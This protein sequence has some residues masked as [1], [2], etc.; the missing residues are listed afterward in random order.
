MNFPTR[1]HTWLLHAGSSAQRRAARP[2]FRCG[3]WLPLALA[4]ALAAC[5]VQIPEAA[6]FT[7]EDADV[8]ALADAGDVGTD[9]GGGIDTLAGD[10]AQTDA[11]GD[12]TAGPCAGG[13]DD[14]NPCTEDKCGTAG[15]C[16]HVS[17]DG[18][19]CSD[20][21]A[22]I[23]GATCAGGKC[24]G[25][26]PKVC[27][28]N[29]PCTADA[30]LPA[31]GCTYTDDD[32][33]GCSDSDS[34]TVDD[35]CLGGKCKGAPM[36][37]GAD[38]CNN[39][40]CI[41]GEC[42]AAPKLSGL[43][44][45]D[46]DACT[47]ATTCN[48]K[49]LCSGGEITN[50]DD[51][52]ACTTDSC[53]SKQ[54]CLHDL[55]T[56][57]CSDNDACT[58]GDA[59]VGGT[60]NPGTGKVCD[61]GNGCTADLCNP[62]DGACAAT[63]TADPCSDGNACTV[64]DA[65]A[66]GKCVPGASLGCDDQNPCTIDSCDAE[67]GACSYAFN[68]ATCE[69]GDGCTVG[70]V[71]VE[72]Q[73]TGGA[74]KQCVDSD[75]CTSDSCDAATGDCAHA[76]IA[77]CG[78]VCTTTADCKAGD[79]CNTA[80]CLSSKCVF[81]PTAAACDDGDACTLAD[82]CQA[83]ACK[84]LSQKNCDDGNPCTDDACA[85]GT[86]AS[87]AN[88]APCSD[89]DA[90]TLG[91]VCAASA[92]VAGTAKVC[93]DGNPCTADACDKQS[94][95]CGSTPNTAA[96][97]DK[98]PCT[99]GDVC[100]DG[101]CLAGGPVNC[102]D[103]N[104][105][106]N[107]SCDPKTGKCLY[108]NSSAPCSDG[109]ACTQGDACAG[110]TCA[111]GTAKSCDDSNPC[112]NDS[113]DPATAACKNVANAADC[114]DGDACTIGDICAAS[115]CKA[116]AA[117]VCADSDTCTNDAC[118]PASGNCVYK[119]ISGCGG[120]CAAAGDCTDGNVCTTDSCVGGKCAFPP[121]TANC[122]DANGCTVGD[123][124]SS[125]S[126]KAGSAKVCDDGNPCTTDACDSKTG[127]CTNAAN[128]ANCDDGNA[129]TAGDQCGS[130]KC[131]AG[132]PIACNDGNPCTDD[133]CDPTSGQCKAAANAAACDDG[134]ACTQGDLCSQA[135]CQAGAAKNCD[136]TNPC[137]TDSCDAATGTCKN[138]ANTL[139]CNDNNACTQGDVCS[140][141]KCQPGA[142]KNCDDGKVCTDD[143]C[144]KTTGACVAAANTATCDDGNKCTLQDVCS[145]GACKA[146]TAVV[147][148]DKDACTNDSCN[149]GDGKCLYAPKIGCGG[150]C[151]T[152]ADCNDGNLCTT[153]QCTSGK[154]TAPSNTAFCDDGNACT[155]NDVCSGG[156]CKSG[157]AKVCD[158]TNPCT[159]DSCNPA[160]G[161]CTY[162]NNTSPCNDNNAC[163]VGDVC[164]AAV[165]KP[166]AAKNCD[167]GKV[168]TDDSCSTSTGNC[169]NTNNTAVCTD[170]NACTSGDVCSGGACVGPTAVNC[171]DGKV[172]S[173]D[174]C[175]TS[176]GCKH[177][178]NT[179]PCSDGSA[180][181]TSDTCSN[182][183]CVG[184]VA[185]NCDDSILCTTD[186]CDPAAGCKHAN[187]TVAC[188]DG[189]VCTQNDA[190]SGGS[191][192]PGA[193]FACNDNDG[194]TTD[195]CNPSDGACVFKPIIGCGGNCASASDCNDANPC[196]NDTC[197]NGKCAHSNNTVSCNDNNACTTSDTCG[198]GACIG[199]AA[200]N[201]D[202]NNPCTTDS[203]D[204]STGCKKVNNTAAC[205]DNNAC[206]TGD[207][208]NG[209]TCV[210]GAAPNCDDNNPCTTDSC[211]TATGCKKVNNT[212]TC[213][214]GSACTTSDT[215]N[216]GACVGTAVNCDDKN[217]CT[218]DSCDKTA[219]CQYQTVA[220]NTPCDDGNACTAGEACSSGTCKGGNQVWV[221]TLAGEVPSP[222]NGFGSGSY[223]DGVGGKARFNSPAGIVYSPKGATLFVADS[224]NHLIRYISSN[225]TVGTVA[226]KQGTAGASD[227][228]GTS[229]TFNL[230][231][232][233]AIGAGDVLLVA[234]TNNS[235]IREIA[236][237]TTVST[238]TGMAGV[239]N[240]N[241][242]L[243]KAKFKAPKGIAVSATGL[244]AVADTGNHAIRLINGNSVTTLAGGLG[245]GYVDGSPTQAKF[246]GPTGIGFDAKG[247]VW[248]ADM[249]N[250]R[251]RVV[252]PNGTVSTA[253]GDGTAGFLDSITPLYARFYYP[254]GLAVLPVPNGVAVLISDSY[255]GRIRRGGGN[256]VTTFAG[257]GLGATDGPGSSAAF[258]LPGGIAV[259]G[260]GTV[261]VADQYNHTIRR[262]R[263]LTSPCTIGNAC[264]AAGQWNPVNSC[265]WCDP[266]SNPS[267][268]S[269]K[270]GCDDGSPCTT[271]DTCGG[272]GCGG[273]GT[274]CNDGNSCTDDVCD[275]V[276]G[277]CS[278]TNN[279]AS[280]NDNNPCTVGD[281][282]GQGSC[283]A[284][285]GNKCDDNNLCTTDNCNS[286]TGG[287]T[288]SN[289][290]NGTACAGSAAQAYPFCSAG[291]CTGLE[292]SALNLVWSPANVGA[293][294]LT[295][296]TRGADNN[297]LVSGFGVAA[298]GGSP[299]S[300]I[301]QV[302]VAAS[303]P[304]MTQVFGTSPREIW[305]LAKRL[306]VGGSQST[307]TA[308][309]YVSQTGLYSA[310]NG[311]QISGGPTLTD[312]L[313]ILR[314][315]M[316][317]PD[318]TT[319]D[320]TYF[321]GG[322]ADNPT[323]TTSKSTL[324]RMKWQSANNSWASTGAGTLRGE[325]GVY[326]SFVS[327]ASAC[328]SAFVPAHVAGIYAVTADE[329]FFAVNTTSPSAAIVNVWT[330][331]NSMN[332]TCASY[333]PGGAFQA[334]TSTGSWAYKFP[335]GAT[336]TGVHGSAN[337]HVL[338]VGYTSSNTAHIARF[339]GAG[340]WAAESPN[341]TMP[342]GWPAFGSATIKP[343][344]VLVRSADAWV[345]GVASQ[346]ICNYMFVLHGTAVG[347][348]WVWDKMVISN[349][350]AV[351][352]DSGNPGHLSVTRIWGDPVDGFVYI[353]GSVAKDSNGGSLV[354]VNAASLGQ[355]A[356]LW[357]VK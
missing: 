97:D 37:C 100:A 55:A 155:L 300:A 93:D 10:D 51:A 158:D 110:G 157:T 216:A 270:S 14:N 12:D 194:C 75:I 244:I 60:C 308:N 265:Q 8:S 232:A 109:D 204:T 138:V 299:Q 215:C 174:S 220:N 175:D 82:T 129:C 68:A 64:G 291:K 214:D 17:S 276:T 188:T 312:G 149:P 248:V 113:C 281:V 63:P 78:D 303:P 1:F 52:N 44:C 7:G 207:L 81:L 159:N 172:C 223:A 326:N 280:C 320:E 41:G 140:Q 306:L 211:D 181:T 38:D 277:A 235:M 31:K 212:A 182:G 257:S 190:C 354:P 200:P 294:R 259:D 199:G 90:C 162:V 101:T 318:A 3:S 268:W 121:S 292:Q 57:P 84:G 178:N 192:V 122:D 245:A 25:G 228:V 153:D 307:P 254:T 247:Y 133:A 217:V 331:N 43:K 311:W 296:A 310:T 69:D 355:S 273:S 252:A 73:C 313:R 16:E 342:S 221:D 124:C 184:G 187:N 314:H 96:C 136:D 94:G 233:L 202:D 323:N 2:D 196:T 297:V 337:N 66:A 48:G 15:T 146:G 128:T 131:Q 336:V 283:T 183:A 176:T 251:I 99:Q 347:S 141:A 289:V 114:S 156:S 250:H 50:C 86:C 104:L 328:V 118:D 288:Y 316:Q 80:A 59:C 36:T 111:S 9:T 19:S 198:G 325:M 269:S 79:V 218:I 264:V 334:T 241:G 61:D 83:G 30:C 322:N 130:G 77:G 45:D 46:G 327:T 206:T 4:L 309:D 74:Q 224:A 282:C 20:G 189:N 154:C 260:A 287:C 243:D 170:G 272:S 163:T 132:K 208:C 137:T 53:D 332:S 225:G 256:G 40:K 49:G 209:G 344:A 290:P 21:N 295:S 165:C 35:K 123:V 274:A 54:G 231:T 119:P 18:A 11:V 135:K 164:A 340:T 333:S 42:T 353:T 210:G 357:R 116:G 26:K 33:A 150:N 305:A 293:S 324:Y 335:T 6:R 230:P 267:G 70:D 195:S 237:D 167:D 76:P 345:A 67:T 98:D 317:G 107:D 102:D 197:T 186:S 85:Q 191:C 346:S 253:G 139:T 278:F 168:C 177:V 62:I 266:A 350:T 285:T 144:D 148:D 343:T 185:P 341:P 226:G 39:A 173:T 105:C 92:C 234:D 127:N 261:Y 58:V 249:N 29:N 222:N 24:T 279:T 32:G 161:K 108:S 302:N 242:S 13:C 106:T 151:A 255:N 229:A 126:C 263:D 286:T 321:M 34:C 298:G 275:K 246:N 125:G 72:G 27:D 95:T 319:N 213:N 301:F 65:C 193:L 180:C 120:N 143:S 91:D 205:N 304:T 169:V 240:I 352:C 28:D 238:L 160:D 145:Q 179:L 112:T 258:Y 201:C 262:I 329:A 134:N 22:C 239:G 271:V 152:A 147:C 315:A 56:A 284:G 71:C 142:A 219:G 5:E 115:A 349:A 203:C 330:A 87:T 117:K 356:V 23:T 351:N 227:G 348:G 47:S 166:G 339:S 103:G 89:N 171:D 338:A 236:I 88:T